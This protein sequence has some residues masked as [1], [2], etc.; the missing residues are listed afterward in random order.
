MKMKQDSPAS[1]STFCSSARKHLVLLLG[2]KQ[3]LWQGPN[4][5]EI[6][7]FCFFFLMRY[8][9][10]PVCHRTCLTRSENT[11]NLDPPGDNEKR[12]GERN[13]FLT[14]SE[15]YWS[16]RNFD[17][18][19]I[20]T[21]LGVFAGMPMMLWQLEKCRVAP[22]W[23]IFVSLLSGDT[24]NYTEHFQRFIKQ[25]VLH[26]MQ[27]VGHHTGSPKAGFLLWIECV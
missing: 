2:L 11:I 1:P 12:Y 25:A 20:E 18:Q 5:M 15:R 22:L 24:W 14:S 27:S 21:E 13:N 3:S 6:N 7:Y 23:G 16:R 17:L 10:A 19:C 9:P 4:N 26:L 8:R